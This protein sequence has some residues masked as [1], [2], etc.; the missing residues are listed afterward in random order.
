MKY[1]VCF[2]AKYVFCYTKLDIADKGKSIYMPS[3]KPYNV[4]QVQSKPFYISKVTRD[5]FELLVD[6]FRFIFKIDRVCWY[7]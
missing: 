4:F 5:V 7:R 3:D 6:N 2:R 1:V